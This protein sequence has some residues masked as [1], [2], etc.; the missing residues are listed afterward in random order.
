[1]KLYVGNIPYSLNDGTLAALFAPFGTVESAKVVAD[2]ASGR[3]K[4]FGFVEMPDEEARKAAQALDG[5]EQGGR[6]I[7]VSEARSKPDAGR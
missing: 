2:G 3:S 5:S 6:T 1:M 7:H 4:G